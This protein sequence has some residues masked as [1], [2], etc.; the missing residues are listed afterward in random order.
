MIVVYQ[1]VSSAMAQDYIP[2]EMSE[3]L[4]KKIGMPGSA[5][6]V[7]TLQKATE[8]HEAMACH[9]AMVCHGIW[10]NKH[11]SWVITSHYV[12]STS[13]VHPPLHINH[14]HTSLSC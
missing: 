4:Q 13:Q 11:L 1:A 7:D 5:L 6:S 3:T 14:I 12:A 8:Y 9:E 2:L 10:R